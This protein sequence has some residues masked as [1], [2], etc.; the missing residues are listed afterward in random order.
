METLDS[1]ET[2]IHDPMIDLARTNFKEVFMYEAEAGRVFPVMG[3][4]EKHYKKRS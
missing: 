1:N 3:M 2:P 4:R